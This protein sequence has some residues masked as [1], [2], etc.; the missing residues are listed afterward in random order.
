METDVLQPVRD[1]ISALDDHALI[2]LL[3]LEQ[4]DYREEALQIARE[5]IRRRD[6]RE[7]SMEEFGTL[8]PQELI[9]TT[10]FCAKCHSETTDESPR[11]T[12]T[13][14]FIGTSLIGRKDPCSICGSVVQS[15]YFC[16]LIPIV[17][18]GRYRIN[19][20]R[21]T[22]LGMYQEAQYVGRRLK[23]ESP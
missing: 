9:A 14:N 10:G 21:R 23:G 6:L 18:L 19:Y 12:G 17:F 11:S 3:A 4:A 15:K 20:T 7:V 16:F 13:F 8:F 5:E 1:H 2:R 22:N